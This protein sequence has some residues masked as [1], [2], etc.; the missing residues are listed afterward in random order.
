MRINPKINIYTD[1]TTILYVGN[2]YEISSDLANFLSKEGYCDI[3]DEPKPKKNKQLDE[4]S[5]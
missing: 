5:A 1:S 2:E 3:I 4:K